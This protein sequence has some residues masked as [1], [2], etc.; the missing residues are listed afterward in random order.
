MHRTS[1][2]QVKVQMIH[3]L[4]SIRSRVHHGA[5]AFA[6]PLLFCDRFSH[7][8]Q[9]A[10]NAL[11]SGREMRKRSD[12]LAW[13]HENMHRR[14]GMNVGEDNRVIV[15]IQLLRGNLT[16][17]DFAE[18]AV[19]KHQTIATYLEKNRGWPSGFHGS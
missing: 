3:G 16:R 12:V 19:H 15:F 13:D 9:V 2:K 18:Q 14:L 7:L 6:Q 4:A 8:V 1:A 17:G 11:V 5:E 10:K